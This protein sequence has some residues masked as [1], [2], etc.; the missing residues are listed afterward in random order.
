M[1]ERNY[2]F[3]FDDKIAFF[4]SDATVKAPPLNYIAMYLTIQPVFPLH[5]VIHDI[6]MKYKL[7]CLTHAL[8]Q[9]HIVQKDLN[10]IGKAG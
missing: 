7:E 6:Y 8:A 9:A 2:L 4:K 3:P 10:E 5:Q 1:L